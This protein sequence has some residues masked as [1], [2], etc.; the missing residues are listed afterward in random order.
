MWVAS[1]I[2]LLLP[3]LCVVVTVEQVM[4]R[5]PETCYDIACESNGIFYLF[6]EGVR[7]RY[8]LL[9]RD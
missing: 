8:D 1:G 4:V 9:V 5:M 6:A 7:G 2:A 3:S